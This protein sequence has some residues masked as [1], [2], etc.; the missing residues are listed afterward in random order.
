MKFPKKVDAS[1]LIQPGHAPLKTYRG[2]TRLCV[3]G[4]AN[5]GGNI[6]LAPYVYA[7]LRMF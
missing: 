7:F 6:S 4:L 2:R 1:A 5:L 3:G